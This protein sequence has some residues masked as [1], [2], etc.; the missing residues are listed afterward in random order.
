MLFYYP[1]KRIERDYFRVPMTPL[2]DENGNL[3]DLTKASKTYL[4]LY[5]YPK[6]MT[7]GCTTEAK[8]FSKHLDSFNKVGARIIGVSKDSPARH[9]KFIEKEEISFTLLSDEAGELC[10]HFGTWVEKSMY[11]KKYMGIDRA[12]FIL[13]KDLTICH[14]WRKVKVAGHVEDVLNTLK[15][16][17]C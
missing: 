10:N 13:D 12:T 17:A 7:P 9:K 3:V 11:G 5:F 14:E 15:K 4:V 8:E 1:L 6:D 16:I 2:P